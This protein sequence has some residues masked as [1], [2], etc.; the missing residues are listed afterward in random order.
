MDCDFHRT[1]CK[2]AEVGEHHLH[3]ILPEVGEDQLH[4][5]SPKVGE[6]Q[7]HI[8]AEVGEDQLHDILPEVG[9]D[10][11]HGI[12]PV[13]FALPAAQRPLAA[14]TMH[15]KSTFNSWH[16]NNNTITI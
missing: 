14:K 11:L 7:L 9:E 16:Y 6:N 2:S 8:L 10:H 15:T 3:D 13:A 4:D 12:L 5:I 1:K